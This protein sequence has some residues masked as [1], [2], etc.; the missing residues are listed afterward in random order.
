VSVRPV[1]TDTLGIKT[2]VKNLNSFRYV[3]RAL[4]YE[5]ERQSNVL[6]EG[7]RI[8]QET[9]LW[10]TA[11]G[12]TFTMRGKEE[13]H[14]YRY[15]PEPDLAPLELDAAW[16]GDIRRSLPELPEA[17]R[18]R[19]IEQYALPDY[20]ARILTQSAELTAYFEATAAACNNPK[21]ASNWIM[22]E[23]T[24]K[25]N[26]DGTDITEVPLP[27]DRLAG[28]IRLVDSGTISGPIAKDVFEKMYGSGQSASEIVEREGLARIDDEAAVSAAVR[29]VIDA[30]AGPVAQYRAGKQ[31]T[32]GFLVG[33]V[34]K[35]M[36]GKANPALVNDLLRRTLDS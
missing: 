10:D 5:I 36:K 23:L 1:G 20:D 29:A 12:R 9:R 34:M 28:L 24:R 13:A 18:L 33:Q 3:Q 30:N 32:F 7:G 27:A 17:R 16:I 8:E 6:R 2:E 11:S 19:L 22:G 31:Q 4:E 26:E 25:M 21:A 15:F 35:A 14:D